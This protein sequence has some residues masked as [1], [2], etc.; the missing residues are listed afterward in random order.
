VLEREAKLDSLLPAAGGRLEGSGVLAAD[1][2]F[3]VV[4]DDAP[5]IGRVGTQLLPG[6][7]GNSLIVQERGRRSGF[8]DIAHD[9]EA[10]RFYVLVEARA[11]GGGS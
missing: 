5:D 4:F 2:C 11:R 6:A 9:P 1:G 10:G 3:Y 8:E 7:A